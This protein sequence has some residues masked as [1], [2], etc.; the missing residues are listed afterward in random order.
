MVTQENASD[1]DVGR[2]PKH[3]SDEFFGV[4]I[5]VNDKRDN[6]STF[7][8]CGEICER[9]REITGSVIGGATPHTA[10]RGLCGSGVS[11]LCALASMGVPLFMGAVSHT[12]CT[13]GGQHGGS[14]PGTP[15][16]A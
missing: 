2:R 3:K 11:P 15:A 14:A 4:T 8:F 9:S 1:L 7:E 16:P 5:R 10:H 6:L 12:V 13:L